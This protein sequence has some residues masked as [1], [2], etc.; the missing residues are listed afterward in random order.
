MGKKKPEE[1]A[2]QRDI[3]VTGA[4][5]K[6]CRAKATALRSDREVRRLRLQQVARRGVRAGRVPD[7]VSQ[8]ALS[9]RV[10]GRQPVGR[11]GRYR[12][13]A[14]IA[15]T[16]SR[17]A[18]RSCRLT[19]TA[20]TTASCRWTRSGSATAWAGSRARAKRDRQHRR[21]ARGRRAV[22]GSVRFCRRVDK[23]LVNRRVIEALVRAGAFDRWSAI[24]RACSRRSASRWGGPSSASA[25]RSR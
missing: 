15:R 6:A 23:R 13:G 21:R 11:H 25:T 20:A 22:P 16:R 2:K 7:R 8:G 18:S 9:G 24:A 14:P 12:Q 10:H 19:S 3:F 17:T 1:M 5:K 4:E